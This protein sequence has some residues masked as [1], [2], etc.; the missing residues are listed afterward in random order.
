MSAGQE[1]MFVCIGLG[2]LVMASG[3]AAACSNMTK[4]KNDK[5]NS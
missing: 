5:Y 1:F 4:S 3:F 2:F